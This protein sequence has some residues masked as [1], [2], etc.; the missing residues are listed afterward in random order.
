MAGFMGYTGS[1]GI[2]GVNGYTGSIGYTGSQGAGFTGSRGDNGVNGYT[3][4][5]GYTGSQGAGFTGSRGDTGF[6]G[7][8][9]LGYTGSAG[10]GFT[11]SAGGLGYTG[12]Q[13]AGFTGS[14][15]YTGSMGGLPSYTGNAKGLLTVDDGETTVSWQKPGFISVSNITDAGYTV[16]ASG[17][18]TYIRITSA[19]GQTIDIPTDVAVNLGGT[20]T[21]RQGGAGKLT[22]S[23]GVGVTINSAETLISRK[24]GS[25]VTLIKTGVNIWDILGDLE[26]SA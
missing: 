17:V 15:G 21:F 12:S 9:G 13:G 18:G 19:T 7:S 16:A 2:D 8:G 6:T 14:R 26:A 3:G 1:Q 5:I 24:Q 23:G 10:A 25:T 4:S 22:F 20:F 11:G